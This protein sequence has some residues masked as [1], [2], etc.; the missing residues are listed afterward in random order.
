MEILL[1]ISPEAIET[2]KEIAQKH[3]QYNNS[4]L[5]VAVAGTN[6]N[7]AKIYG[8]K[9]IC[10]DGSEE[11]YDSGYAADADADDDAIM[12]WSDEDHANFILENKVLPNIGYTVHQRTLLSFFQNMQC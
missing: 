12:G 8:I 7:G 2:Y 10:E 5:N 9:M 1:P 3:L 4:E 11:W 6:N